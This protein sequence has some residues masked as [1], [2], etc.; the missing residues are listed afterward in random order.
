LAVRRIVGLF[1]MVVLVAGAGAQP[2]PSEDRSWNSL[3]AAQR[4]ALAPLQRDWNSIDASGKQRWL[5]VA[6]RLPSMPPDERARTQDR[7]AAW[8]RL[9]PEQRGQARLR[10]QEAR[11]LSPQERQERWRAYQALP[12]ERREEL[13][14]DTGARPRQRA[15]PQSDVAPKSN[16]VPDPAEGAAVRPVAPTVVQTRPGASTRLLN[17]PAQQ[18]SHQQTGMP[19]IAATPGFVDS[20]TLL[21]KR[22][23]QGA[24]TRPASAAEQPAKPRK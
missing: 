12:P 11:Q 9:T 24:A 7:M 18:P 21:P 20:T 13:A 8:S 10:Y 4:T 3:T 23:A 22:G 2:A 5:E 19:K 16:V 6:A 1:A 15:G 14:R 17:Q